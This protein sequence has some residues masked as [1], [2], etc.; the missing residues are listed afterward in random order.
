MILDEPSA[1]L[2]AESEHE[3]HLSIS[4]HRAGST[5][6]LI[7]HRLNAVHDADR[8]A[9]LGDGRVLEAGNHREL[10][11]GGGEY[12]RLFALQADGYVDE[13]SGSGPADPVQ[14]AAA[15]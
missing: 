2:D 8:I 11:Q 13:P 10:M 7:S 3:I 5:S 12:A 15:S 1:G 9:V 4:R 14:A 6:L